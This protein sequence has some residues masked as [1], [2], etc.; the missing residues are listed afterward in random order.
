MRELAGFGEPALALVGDKSL[1]NE[2][3]KFKEKD[4]SL[5]AYTSCQEGNRS[6][7]GKTSPE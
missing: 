7:K 1:F 4:F 6:F 2:K 3:E 5:K